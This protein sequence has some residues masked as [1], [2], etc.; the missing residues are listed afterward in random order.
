MQSICVAKGF[1]NQEAGKEEVYD[2]TN[3]VV[4]ALAI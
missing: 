2:F 4:L 1:E 3:E